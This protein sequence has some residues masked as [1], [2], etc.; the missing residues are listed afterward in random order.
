[1]GVDLC[2]ES[3]DYSAFGYI[4]WSMVL[5]LARQ[6]GW[7]PQG[8][9]PPEGLANPDDWNGEYESS[10]G[11]RVAAS[12]AVALADALVAAVDDPQ[13]HVR[14]LQMDS[15]Q[16]QQVQEQVGPELAAS[17]VGVRDFEE[18]RECL[19]EFSGFCR[20]GAFRIE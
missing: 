11:Q 4:G 13:L 16:R 8:T 9:E 5:E 7:Q 1:M 18:Y 3:G 15:E 2:S 14:V 17:F 10:D 19:R 6:Y 12:D 20:K